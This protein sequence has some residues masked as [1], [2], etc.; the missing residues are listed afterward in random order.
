MQAL[1]TPDNCYGGPP[2]DWV[3]IR[4]VTFTMSGASVQMIRFVTTGTVLATLIATVA[5]SAHAQMEL[6]GH[7]GAAPGASHIDHGPHESQGFSFHVRQVAGFNTQSGPRGDNAVSAEN[8]QMMVYRGSWGPLKVEPHVMTS[9]E[10]WLLPKSGAPQLFQAGETYNGE[11]IVDRQHPHDLWMEI[12]EKLIFELAPGSNVYIVG[13][14]VGQPALGPEAFMH[15]T[16]AR[17]LPWAPL[18]HHFQDSTHVSMGVMTAGVKF[19]LIEVAMSQFNGR[20]PDEDR[21]DLDKG[22]LDSWSSQ[23]KLFLW[24]GLYGQASTAIL[25]EPEPFEPGDQ[26]RTTVSVH[27]NSAADV[28]PGGFQHA[29]SLIYGA[30][31][32]ITDDEDTAPAAVALSSL[33][34]GAAGDESTKPRKSWLLESD[35]TWGWGLWFMTRLESIDR[36]GLGLKADEGKSDEDTDHVINAWTIGAFQD[37]EALSTSRVKTGVGADYTMHFVDAATREDYGDNPY[38]AHAFLMMNAAW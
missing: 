38:G 27:W 14:P 13:G 18:G 10:P 34:G 37:I 9:L 32:R 12:T 5:S 11:P 2:R 31:Q 29:T 16:S 25:K 33:S 17:H 7:H 4:I 15:R 22:K 36:H 23:V 21:T 1:E 8:Y 20:E 30:T 24:D 26:R 35:M 19:D 6:H 28:P 3:K